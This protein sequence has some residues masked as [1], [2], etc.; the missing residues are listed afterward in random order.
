MFRPNAYVVRPATADDEQV[1]S[2]LA[3]L[4]RERSLRGPALIGEIDGRPAAAVALASGRVIADP[5][6]RTTELKALLRMRFRA[7]RGLPQ[8][9]SLTECLRG[10]P[11][12]P[13]LSQRLR[14][15]MRAVAAART[16]A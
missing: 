5:S 9:P 14:A 6:Q 15:G 2:R 10:F 8:I 7:I 11:W 1:L 12:M 16:P 13:A 3:E 4:D